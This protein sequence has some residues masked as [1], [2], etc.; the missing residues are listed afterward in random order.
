MKLSVVL[1]THNPHAGRLAR[2]LD[3]LRRQTMAAD[4]WETI[5]V[6]NASGTPLELEVWRDSAPTDMRIVREETLGLTAARRCGLLEARGDV[7][8]MVDD[9]NVLSPDY[10]EQAAALI[11]EHPQLGAAGGKSRPEFETPPADWVS[12]FHGLLACR[13]LGDEILIATSL[14][15][16]GKK[17]N[18]YP[19]FAPIG[20]GMVL[21]RAAVEVWLQQPQSRLTDRRGGE[22]TSGGDNDIILA[23]LSQGW[24]VGYFPALSLTHLIPTTRV[25]ADYLARLNHGIAKSW[26]EVLTNYQACPWSPIAPWTLPLR[27]AKAWLTYRAWAGPA[28]R[29]RWRG[30][31][32]HFEGLAAVSHTH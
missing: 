11:T 9:D 18:E 28:A 16:D 3:S 27:Q 17:R 1:P 19:A 30:A 6:D 20:A 22:L 26:I 25:Q 12:E 24:H 7:I 15:H 2:T 8:V 5:L 31:C 32:G 14:W 4:Q 23:L 10:L 13:D 21:R 29:V